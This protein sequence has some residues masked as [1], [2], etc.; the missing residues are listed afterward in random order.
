MTINI[1]TVISIAKCVAELAT[2]NE[3]SLFLASSACV[4]LR[5][6]VKAVAETRRGD[7]V[8]DDLIFAL[9]RTIWEAQQRRKLMPNSGVLRTEG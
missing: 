1:S 7:F 9:R 5:C 2:W 4:A 8:F 6:V 3:K